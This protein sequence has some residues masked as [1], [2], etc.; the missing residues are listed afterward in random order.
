MTMI[1]LQTPAKI[2]LSLDITG[3]RADGYHELASVFQAIS[4]FD[5]VTISKSNT[6]GISL[7]CNLKYIPCSPKN[8]AY[9]AAAAFLQATG[10]T[11]DLHIHIEKHIPTQAGMGGGSSDGAAV[12]FGLNRLLDC[13]LSLQELSAIAATLGADVPF[14]L[15]GGTA[16]A[17]GIGEQLT[18]LKPLRNLPLI[19]AKGNAGISTPEAYARIDGLEHPQ[20]PDTNAVKKAI[21]TA[22]LPLLF[23]SCGNLFEQVTQL[24]DVE[25]CKDIMLAHGAACAMMTGSGAAV[26]GLCR[27]RTKAYICRRLLL[28]KV[29]YAVVCQTKPDGIRIIN[30]T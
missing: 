12:L 7:S 8:I 22:N 10:R 19:V 5:V 2:N 13:K 28:R 25:L 9:K 21:E 24:P 27:N 1:T 17:E 6:P 11:A 26:F 16:F 3:R 4:I 23:R 14:F 18:P 20:H 15:L 30:E 29:P